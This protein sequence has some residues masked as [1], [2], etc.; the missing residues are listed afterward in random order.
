MERA[1]CSPKEKEMPFVVTAAF[2]QQ[3]EGCGAGRRTEAQQ[4]DNEWTEKTRLDNQ[5]KEQKL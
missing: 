2:E 5:G 4:E 1:G 3:Q